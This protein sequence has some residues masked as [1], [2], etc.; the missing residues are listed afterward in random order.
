M[1]RVPRSSKRGF[2]RA[3]YAVARNETRKRSPLSSIRDWNRYRGGN[4]GYRGKSGFGYID[5]GRDF[6]GSFLGRRQVRR[7]YNLVVISLISI[8]IPPMP[9]FNEIP[10]LERRNSSNAAI[11]AS[12][13]AK[14][15]VGELRFYVSINFPW[16]SGFSINFLAVIVVPISPRFKKE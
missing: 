1:H 7:N 4:R 6:R 13:M 2:F 5:M 16:Q 12:G 10:I 15:L 9:F 14:Y 11:T 3:G 8:K